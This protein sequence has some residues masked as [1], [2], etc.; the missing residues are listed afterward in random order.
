MKF[1]D[2]IRKIF[3]EIKEIDCSAFPGEKVSFNAKG[4]NHLIYKSD[5]SMRSVER[6]RTNIRLLPRAI[7]LLKLM[8]IFQEEASY[9]IGKTIFHFWAFEGVVDNRRIKVIVRQ[10]GN[11]KKYF[12][13][14]IPCWRKDRFGDVKNSKSD[15]RKN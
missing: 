6:I 13:S 5:R 3:D 15:L 7:K 9:K 14:V 8:P 12:W 10:K 1:K 2:R 11:G 4:I